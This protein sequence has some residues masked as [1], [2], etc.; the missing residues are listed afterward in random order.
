M[1][2]I[3]GSGAGPSRATT[4]AS[5]WPQELYDQDGQPGLMSYYESR[6]RLLAQLEEQAKQIG[7]SG[8]SWG[9]ATAGSGI[10]GAVT[11]LQ[12]NTQ[13]NESQ[14]RELADLR[15]QI[16]EM[17]EEKNALERLLPALIRDA[18]SDTMKVMSGDVSA[19]QVVEERRQS[20]SDLEAQYST[21]RMG[22]LGARTTDPLAQQAIRTE[23]GPDITDEQINAIFNQTYG[24]PSE[25]DLQQQRGQMANVQSQMDVRDRSFDQGQANWEAQQR[26]AQQQDRFAN[27]QTQF[28][29][30]AYQRGIQGTMANQIAR[31]Q[32]EQWELARPWAVPQGTQYTPGWAPGGIVS[33]VFGKLGL[34]FAP[35]PVTRWDLPDPYEPYR[36]M[37]VAPGQV[38]QA[39]AVPRPGAYPAAGQGWQDQ[40]QAFLPMLR[41]GRR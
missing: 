6:K 16:A 33:Q 41:G 38:P 27:Q 10:M 13:L 32:T 2:R 25:L 40:F 1:A 37:G 19:T 7:P 21:A 3:P 35:R 23:W 34:N 17:R 9:E 15:I 31:N 26:Y 18:Q 22:Q 29:N 5:H 14:R 30:E 39:P 24:L 12:R 8:Y 28:R 4:Y 11:G 36:R 20:R